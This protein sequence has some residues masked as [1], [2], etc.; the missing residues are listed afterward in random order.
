M[1]NRG[2]RCGQWVAGLAGNKGEGLMDLNHLNYWYWW[3]P[4]VVLIVFDM[5]A[6]EMFFLWMGL[7]CG[8]VGFIVLLEPSLGW[9]YQFM[10][11][12]IFSIVSIAA[13]RLYVQPR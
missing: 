8:V 9:Q 6:R 3:I 2:C 1:P 11:F 7:A 10:V 4:G 5:L 12:S 13:W